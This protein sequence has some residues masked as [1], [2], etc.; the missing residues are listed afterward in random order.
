MAPPSTNFD[1]NERFD[2]DPDLTIAVV[3]LLIVLLYLCVAFEYV[4]KTNQQ[5]QQD[6]AQIIQCPFCE[7]NLDIAL[8]PR[9]IYQRCRRHAISNEDTLPPYTIIDSRPPPSYQE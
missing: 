6:G 1:L 9:T 4:L 7:A 3:F 8:N 5:Q 2:P